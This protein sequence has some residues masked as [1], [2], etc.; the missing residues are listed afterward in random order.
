MK[1]PTTSRPT[2][3]RPSV[4]ASNLVWLAVAAALV[5][6]GP[7]EP[8]PEV[9]TI[10]WS[11]IPAAKPAAKLVAAQTVTLPGASVDLPSVQSNPIDDSQIDRAWA[12]ANRD[13]VATLKKEEEVALKEPLEAFRATQQAEADRKLADRR[14]ELAQDVEAETEAFSAAVRKHGDQVGW[15]RTELAWRV[16]FP[17]PDPKSLRK[18]TGRYNYTQIHLDDAARLRTDIRE[19]EDAFDSVWGKRLATAEARRLRKLEDTRTDLQKQVERA[20]AAEAERLRRAVDLRAVQIPQPPGPPPEASVALGAQT[21]A[22]PP[23]TASMPSLAIPSADDPVALAKARLPV[24]LAQNRVRLAG[25]GEKGRDA[26]GEF[27]T[28]LKQFEIGG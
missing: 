5:G 15:D 2:P 24:F 28:W 7:K 20:T 27:L 1:G 6:C 19:K 22:F 14:A 10:D 8:S 18:P 26:T 21:I 23:V 16:G 12:Q 13:Q 3:P 4:R 17:D 25:P 11:R 9:V